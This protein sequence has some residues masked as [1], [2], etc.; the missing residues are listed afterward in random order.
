MPQRGRYMFGN[1]GY[2][3]ILK[4]L[5]RFDSLWTIVRYTRLESELGDFT[6]GQQFVIIDVP[7]SSRTETTFGGHPTSVTTHSIGPSL[8]RHETCDLLLG[9][10]GACFFGDELT[11]VDIIIESHLGRQRSNTISYLLFHKF[12]IVAFGSCPQW[13]YC[14]MFLDCSC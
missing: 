11:K 6:A 1:T 2:T 5:P 4:H 10:L 7:T 3:S 8:H 12:R 9:A 14:P 13:M